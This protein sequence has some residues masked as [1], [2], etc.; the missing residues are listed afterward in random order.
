MKYL[1]AE[2]T[3]VIIPAYEPPRRFVDYVR[4]LVEA[5]VRQVVVVN[6]GS[7]EKYRDIY[8]TIA[9]T[10]GCTVLSYGENR[11]K[12]Y[13]L[14]YAMQYC[15]ENFSEDTV[16]VTADCD[17]QHLC[18]D[19]MKVAVAAMEHPGKLVLGARDFTS[20][21][22]PARSRSG[23][24]QTRRMFRLLYRISLSD[25][26]TGLRGFSHA[27]LD[28]LIA[29]RGTRFEYEMNMLIV[30]HKQH[31]DI[32]EVPIET[33]Y[34]EKSDDVERLSHFRTFSD[35]VRVIS[36]LFKNL[37]WYLVSSVSSAILDVVAFHLFLVYLFTGL[38]DALHVLFATV[39]ARVISSLVNFAFNFGLVFNGKSKASI[40]KYYFLW[41]IQLSIS[42]GVAC[43]W[44]MVFAGKPEIFVT[45]C[46]G[47]T[48]LLLALASY[49]IQ[50]RWVFVEA[51][52]NRL[53]FFGPLLRFSRMILRLFT[54]RYKSFVVA[55]ET[56]PTVYVCRHLNM[57]GP[58]TLAQYS[59]FDMHPM[60]LH[61]FFR[62]RDCYRQY[63]TYTFT[64]RYGKR[65]IRKFFGK[66]AAFFAALFV[67]PLVRST[68]A[69][70][71]YR[72]TDTKTIV[73]YRRAMEYLEKNENIVLFPDVDYT[74]DSNTKGE[75]YTGFLLLDRLYHRK[76]KKHLNFAVLK[77]DDERRSITVA[78]QFRFDDS[79]DFY[80]QMPDVASRIADCLM[81]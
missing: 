60:V 45:L 58:I 63:S 73:T 42:Y 68:K 22:V 43:F 71:V 31:V 64:E 9:A 67:A 2:Q 29:I 1:N 59:T 36:T 37:G 56:E 50:S 32:V 19:I 16:F 62:F 57:H 65:G 35:S 6:D 53:H 30:L 48:D 4:E 20:P 17:G 12:G 46:K 72:G 52:H 54:K 70:P 77:I 34:N 55:S 28:K 69:I 18:D 10:E 76:Y 14:K 40:I 7:G 47:M 78:G 25:T 74:A 66:V 49:Q 61:V 38:P 33:V 5:G 51:E 80:T 3:V 8:D 81:Q 44:S 39:L 11:G 21:N 75:I 23:N 41:T 24:I 27:M 15:R 79:S 13:A 26:Q